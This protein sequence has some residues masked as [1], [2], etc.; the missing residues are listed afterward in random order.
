MQTAQISV[1]GAGIAGLSSALALSAL[2]GTIVDV[3]ERQSSLSVAGAGIQ[4]GP[5]AFAAIHALDQKLFRALVLKA[6]YPRALVMRDMESGKTLTRLT[7]GNHMT[8]AFGKPYGVMHRADLQ[9]ALL[10]ACQSKSNI[11]FHWGRE[12]NK[13]I[14]PSQ[15]LT[16]RAD[17]LWS[18]ASK[19]PIDARGLALR[20]SY[21]VSN[22]S[23]DQIEVRLWVSPH[24]HIVS[25]PVRVP[26]E[27]SMQMNWVA[28]LSGK[29]YQHAL[30]QL[31]LNG[32]QFDQK[33]WLMEINSSSI[34]SLFDDVCSDVK[35]ELEQLQNTS[36]WRV[37]KGAMQPAKEWVKSTGAARSILIGDAAHAMLPHLAQGAALALEDSLALAHR[38]KAE[39]SI[40]LALEGFVQERIAR[41][42]HAQRQA[43][44]YGKIYHASGL[45]RLGRNLVLKAPALAPKYGGL[46]WLYSYRDV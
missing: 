14:A 21:P 31:Q 8:Q 42:H 16:V 4:L 19:A 37:F 28:F 34:V 35:I 20:G 22:L 15:T 12:D 29:L 3:F 18:N 46:E 36:A 5:N 33:S 45:V 41:S 6:L 13:Q 1:V 11:R 7:L 27:S 44:R 30:R 10:A 40:D 32:S 2:D 39:S 38:L 17:G 26:G 23:P 43:A 24:R 9:N 25:Y